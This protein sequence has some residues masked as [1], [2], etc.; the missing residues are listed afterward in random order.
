MRVKSLNAT[1]T[2]IKRLRDRIAGDLTQLGSLCVSLGAE[3]ERR[4]HEEVVRAGGETDGLDEFQNATRSLKRDRQAVDAA[5][6]I[7]SSKVMGASGYEF[8]EVAEVA[9]KER[10]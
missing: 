4:Y 2:E 7:V 1:K 3:L 9:A 5:L 8:E 10:K 6:A